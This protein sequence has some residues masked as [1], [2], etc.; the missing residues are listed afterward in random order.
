MSLPRSAYE[1]CLRCGG[2]V[3]PGDPRALTEVTGYTRPRGAGGANHVIDRRE[4]GRYVCPRC[5]VAVQAG[6]PEA[7]TSLV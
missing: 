6:I 4:T 3:A 5:A 2:P 7:Q 1:D